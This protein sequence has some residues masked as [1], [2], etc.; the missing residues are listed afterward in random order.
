MRRSALISLLLVLALAPRTYV[1][2]KLYG[3]NVVLA[4]W[5]EKR[6][7]VTDSHFDRLGDMLTSLAPS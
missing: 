7:P 2:C 1:A 5:N 4:W 3:E 6:K